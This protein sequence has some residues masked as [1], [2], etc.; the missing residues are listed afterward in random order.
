[1]N[2]ISPSAFLPDDLERA[3][4]VG[5]VWR[6]APVQGPVIVLVRHGEVYDIS[7]HAA[8]MS[9]LLDSTDPAG[10]VR[11]LD[12]ESLGRVEALFE[13]SLAEPRTAPYLLA[14]CDLQAI[15]AC[16]VTFAVS[17]LERVIE[18]QAGGDAA[19]ADQLRQEIRDIIGADLSRIR[20][21]SEQAMALKTELQARG[22]WSQ[23][24]EVGI[25]PD[26]EVFSKAQTLS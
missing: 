19:R 13:N 18:E 12:G 7:A 1:M 15:K 4:L 9:D 22:A 3:L 6:D 5:R 20:P 17:L 11:D 2:S 16:G 21:G 14:P 23:Y 10:F 25:G 26:A 24:M 8:T